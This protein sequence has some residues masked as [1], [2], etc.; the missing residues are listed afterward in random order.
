MARGVSSARRGTSR[1]GQRQP[2]FCDRDAG[3]AQFAASSCRVPI[4][5]EAFHS[6]LCALADCAGSRVHAPVVA[7]GHLA[8]PISIW[9]QVPCSPSLQVR[10]IV[11]RLPCRSGLRLLRVEPRL[12]LPAQNPVQRVSWSAA[13]CAGPRKQPAHPIVRQKPGVDKTGCRKRTDALAG[14]IGAVCCPDVDVINPQ[15][16]QIQEKRKAGVASL[17]LIHYTRRAKARATQHVTPVYLSPPLS[18]PR[19]VQMRPRAAL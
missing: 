11:S 8:K 9:Q 6:E 13:V 3:V 7:N 10:R 17:D 16:R 18:A 15:R 14:A 2:P 4:A 19:A 5:H 12:C 1:H